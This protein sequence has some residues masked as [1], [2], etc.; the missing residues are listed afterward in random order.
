MNVNILKRLTA[1]ENR[2]SKTDNPDI[3]QIS[4]DESKEKYVVVEVYC[5]RDGK[6]NVT[7]G[8]R[9]IVIYLDHYKEYIFAE[10][11]HAQVLLDLIG[12][13]D[14]GNLHAFNTDEMRKKCRFPKNTAFSICY[15]GEEKGEKQLEAVFE[16]QPYERG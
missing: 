13:P 16:I 1:V 14:N 3:I 6:G 11:T 2:I 15:T 4:Y 8:G 10:T 12:S 5:N 7:Q 9:R